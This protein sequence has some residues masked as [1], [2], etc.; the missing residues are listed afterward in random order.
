MTRCWRDR[1]NELLG[2]GMDVSFS[3]GPRRV[4]L[5][6]RHPGLACFIRALRAARLV[7]NGDWF[8]SL[9]ACYAPGRNDDSDRL[10][11]PCND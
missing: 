11:A 5:H 2:L 4:Y 1:L 9:I 8:R 10:D 6:L 3:Y 7:R